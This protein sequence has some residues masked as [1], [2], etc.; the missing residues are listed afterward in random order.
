ML[1]LPYLKRI[2]IYFTVILKSI[3]ATGTHSYF[4]ETHVCTYTKSTRNISNQI[5]LIAAARSAVTPSTSCIIL[6]H[7]FCLDSTCSGG[8]LSDVFLSSPYIIA[9]LYRAR[10]EDHHALR[11]ACNQLRL[12]IFRFSL[13]LS[14]RHA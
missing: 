12:H 4:P 2:S 11:T 6:A 1:I 5:V 13:P 7:N 14:S 9:A 8:F 10:R 3:H